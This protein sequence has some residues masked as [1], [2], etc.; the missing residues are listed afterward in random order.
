MTV[1]SKS[2]QANSQKKIGET[3]VKLSKSGKDSMGLPI[4]NRMRIKLAAEGIKNQTEAS[5]KLNKMRS[6]QS[7]D[8]S[9]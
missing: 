2:A 5:I 1:F 3:Q 8:D 9:Q 6:A 7:T 4:S